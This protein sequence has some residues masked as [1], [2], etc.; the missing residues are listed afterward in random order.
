[1][2]GKVCSM[3]GEVCSEKGEIVCLQGKVCSVQRKMCSV[4][5]PHYFKNNFATKNQMERKTKTKIKTNKKCL[6]IHIQLQPTEGYTSY[7]ST[8]NV[9][10]FTLLT[11]FKIFSKIASLTDTSLATRTLPAEAPAPPRQ[12]W[13]M[14][15]S[16]P[17]WMV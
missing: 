16:T 17:S 6:P 12:T 1:M 10:K 5:P 13:K 3:Q 2:Q 9:V 15:P 11:A 4:P 8:L 7:I 14:S